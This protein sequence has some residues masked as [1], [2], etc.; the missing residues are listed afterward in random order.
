[1]PLLPDLQALRAAADAVDGTAATV[2]A[3]AGH[4]GG[5]VD[6]LPWRG[7]RREVTA[8][9]AGAALAAAAGQ[10]AAERDL[11]RALRE[12]ALEVEHEL[13]MLAALAARA[14][15]HLD[16]LL[17]RARALVEATGRAVADAAAAA[18]AR[19]VVEVMT[20]DPAGALNEARQLAEEALERLRAITLRLQALPE[21]HDPVWRRLAPQILAWHP[22]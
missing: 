1:M 5:L 21:A 3:D 9:A 11:A 17:R 18:V 8:R 14:R 16:E 12:L 10:A 2:E 6:G 19:V 4:V 22:V 15:A 20:F 13:R 7:L